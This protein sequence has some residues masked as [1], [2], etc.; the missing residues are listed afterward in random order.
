MGCRVTHDYR[1]A[2]MEENQI[3]Q[4]S[5]VFYILKDGIL[6]RLNSEEKKRGINRVVVG[7][8]NVYSLA[9][10][11]YKVGGHEFSGPIDDEVTLF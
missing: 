7:G 8:V 9:D 2:N 10:P 6:R 4:I 1:S 5:G 11:K 3:V